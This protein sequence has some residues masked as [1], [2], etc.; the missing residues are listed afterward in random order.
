MPTL[1]YYYQQR[2]VFMGSKNVYENFILEFI[3]IPCNNKIILIILMHIF[4]DLLFSIFDLKKLLTSSRNRFTIS[5]FL[6]IM[7]PTS[8]K[9]KEKEEKTIITVNMNACYQMI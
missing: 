3:T 8:C 2:G 4:C 1:S 5:P 9:E 6:P 7:L